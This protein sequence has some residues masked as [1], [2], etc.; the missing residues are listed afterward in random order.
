MGIKG[1]QTSIKQK[2]PQC[3]VAKTNNKYNHI[4]FDLNFILHLASNG[5]RNEK[6]LFSKMKSIINNILNEV[7]PM[8]SISFATDSSGSYA[9]VALQHHRRLTMSHQVK[10]GMIDPMLFSVGTGFMQ[11][12]YINLEEYFNSLKELYNINIIKLFE[13]PDEAEIK[14]I[15][16]M[17]KNHQVDN[18]HLFISNDADVI[19]L[20]MAND[21]YKN[22]FI[23][24]KQHTLNIISI[25]IL[26]ETIRENN[27]DNKKNIHKDYAL[28]SLLQGNDY[29]PK[30]NYIMFDKIWKRYMDSGLDLVTDNII[31]KDHLLYLLLDS[32]QDINKGFVNN[33]VYSKYDKN[34]YKN[35]VDGLYWCFKMYSTGE[36]YKYDYMNEYTAPHPVG[37]IHY[38]RT[39]DY[40]LYPEPNNK[41]IPDEIYA[42]LVLPKAAKK[43]INPKFY[44][45]ID[46]KLQFLYE[47]ENCDY[48]T[49]S[50]KTISDGHKSIKNMLSYIEEITD[51]DKT[52]EEVENVNRLKQKIQKLNAEYTEHKKTHKQRLTLDDINH[53]IE[54][55]K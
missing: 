37:L 41:Y 44:N 27:K 9:K 35:Y 49:V 21:L 25:K 4:Y 13:S 26:E 8:T 43:L 19:V 2:Y 14:L 3:F 33:F 7:Q 1:F 30:V 24:V 10:P 51:E 34:M 31:N 11:T 54:T 55:L 52:N 47:I 6:T 20:C 40:V 53:V 39:V 32:L 28:L 18:T 50:N 15:R 38:L 48:C 12:F 23:G 45:K 46:T 29:L 5:T 22:I 16:Q 36:C 42:V 17:K